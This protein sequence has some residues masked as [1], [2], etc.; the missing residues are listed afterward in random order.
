[1]EDRLKIDCKCCREKNLYEEID[2]LSID[3]EIKERIISKVKKERELIDELG[4][5]LCKCH[6]E[7]EILENAVIYLSKQ[8]AKN[9]KY[10][11]Y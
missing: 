9:E 8:V 6:D 7:I 4:D 10:M 3:K 1:M 2:A 5:K 11:G